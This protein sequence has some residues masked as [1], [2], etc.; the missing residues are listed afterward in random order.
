MN[1]EEGLF[2]IRGQLLHIFDQPGREDKEKGTVA[3]DTPKVQIMGGI[4]Q[5]NGQVR[6]EI[7]T[8]SCHSPADFHSLKGK[9]ITVPIGMFSPEKGTVI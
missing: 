8:L 5:R 3:D 4:P 9:L 2:Q 7:V 6:F 1:E